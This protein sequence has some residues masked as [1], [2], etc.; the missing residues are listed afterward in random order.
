MLLCIVVCWV[1]VLRGMLLCYIRY[2]YSHCVV[3][4]RVFCMSCCVVTRCV[5]RLHVARLRYTVC[6]AVFMCVSYDGGVRD[7]VCCTSLC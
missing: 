1:V 6:H 4:F 7:V 3:V 5:S 2:M